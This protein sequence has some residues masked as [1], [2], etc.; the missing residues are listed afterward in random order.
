MSKNEQ[1]L[2]IIGAK[3]SILMYRAFG[4][5]TFA[6]ADATEAESALER[7][8]AVNL[9]DERKTSEYA[10][11]FVEENFYQNFPE[12]LTDRLAKK[13]LPAVIPV[14]APGSADRNFAANRLRKIVERAVGSDILG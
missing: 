4:I 12:D 8:V 5:E 1:K 3:S 13:P 7:L 10:I 6:V 9:G 11:V 14:P 2:A